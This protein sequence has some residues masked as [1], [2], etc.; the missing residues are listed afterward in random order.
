MSGTFERRFAV[1]SERDS[2]RSSAA[3]FADRCHCEWR[4]PARGNADDDVVLA[5]FALFHL[6]A[7]KLFVVFAGFGG[8]IE[9]LGSAGDDVLHS[10]RINIK[11]WR[12]FGSVQ[13]TDASAGACSHVNQPSALSKAG[14]NQIDSVRDLR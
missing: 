8:R 10:T 6:V 2:S 9:S 12:A 7:A 14:S 4:A 13:S 1:A 11:G 3:G 5:R